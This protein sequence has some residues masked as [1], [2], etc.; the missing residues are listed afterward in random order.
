MG[1]LSGL[2]PD[3]VFTFFEEI[4][5]IPHGS[6][7]VEAISDY[8]AGFAGER[9][10]QCIQDAVKNIIII[11]EATPGYEQEPAVILQDRKSVV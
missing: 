8:L 3:R 1:V 6:G 10:L 5:Q 2:K 4:A 9:G 7:N 11:K